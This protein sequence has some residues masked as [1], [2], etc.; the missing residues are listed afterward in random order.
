M[1]IEKEVLDKILNSNVDFKRLYTEHSELKL[2]IDNMNKT[3]F[4]NTAEEVKK[5]QHQKTVN[6]RLYILQWISRQFQ[7][8]LRGKSS[9][10]HLQKHAAGPT[11]RELS[12]K[13]AQDTTKG[14]SLHQ[15]R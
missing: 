10:P 13:L 11:G 15:D 2:K 9:D 6:L 3:K 1:E 12:L 4:L 5:K 8:I 7:G 14:L